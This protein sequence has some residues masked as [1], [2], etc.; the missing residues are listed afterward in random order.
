MT[1]EANHA[2]QKVL[3]YYPDAI[4]HIWDG[5]GNP[6]VYISTKF[7]PISYWN[8]SEE[9]AWIDAWYAIQQKIIEKLS[10]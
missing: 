10:K 5:A 1:E 9:K 2:K 3:E 4:E 8:T 6:D 7:C